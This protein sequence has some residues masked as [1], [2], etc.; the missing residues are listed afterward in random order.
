MTLEVLTDLRLALQNTSSHIQRAVVLSLD[1]MFKYAANAPVGN[2]SA[3]PPITSGDGTSGISNAFAASAILVNRDN[4]PGIAVIHAL[5][6][7]L[8]DMVVIVS[9]TAPSSPSPVSSPVSSPRTCVR[10]SRSHH[11]VV[12]AFPSNCCRFI[13]FFLFSAVVTLKIRKT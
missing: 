5:V 4:N 8:L 13:C 9:K 2:A 11:P 10:P 12:P 6:A 3:N 1:V 7:G